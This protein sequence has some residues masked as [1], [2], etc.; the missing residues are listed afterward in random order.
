MADGGWR[1]EMKKIKK[2]IIR[3]KKKKK[4]RKY[5]ERLVVKTAVRFRFKQGDRQTDRQ[6]DS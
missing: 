5:K 1:M 3:K 4:R 2:I 6:M